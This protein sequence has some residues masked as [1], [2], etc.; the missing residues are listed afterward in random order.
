MAGGK[1]PDSY[2]DISL[3]ESPG[4]YYLYLN[5]SAG[6]AR[7]GMSQQFRN[8]KNL[9]FIVLKKTPCGLVENK[10]ATVQKPKN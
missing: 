5:V 8:K 10:K 3:C 9:V 7:R 1:T 2:W 6:K 4:T